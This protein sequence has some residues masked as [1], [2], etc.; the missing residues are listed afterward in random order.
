M[1]IKISFLFVIGMCFCCAKP[2]HAQYKK[3][4]Y[5]TILVSAYVVNGDTLPYA[6]INPVFVYAKMPAWLA[7]Q[8][9]R[10][11]GSF[12]REYETLKYNVRKVYPYAIMA[13]FVMHDIDSVFGKLYSK[14][15]KAIYKENKEAALNKRFK[16]E[17][18]DLTITQGQILVKLINRQTGKSV[19]DIVK[20]L[21][22]GFTAGFYQGIA[23]L[24]DNNLK[25]QYSPNGA[26]ADIESIV[27]E[28]EAS[29]K[30]V[31]QRI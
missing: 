17:L 18:T 6:Y 20:N 8:R 16:N 29:G 11:K 21:K 10:E 31:I 4:I 7:N 14:D 19:Y 2:L 1:K 27:R 5:D 28:I 13:S 25:N 30:F 23:Y 22:G 3:S 24:F 9:R 26:D 12:N 15:A